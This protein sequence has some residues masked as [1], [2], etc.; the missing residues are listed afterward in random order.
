[1][2]KIATDFLNIFKK[3]SNNGRNSYNNSV[4]KSGEKLY[5]IDLRDKW[6]YDRWHIKNAVNI[7]FEKFENAEFF[8]PINLKIVL[9]CDR[10]GKRIIC[11]RKLAKRGYYCV[12]VVD[13]IENYTG[14]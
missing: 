2:S 3:I 13:G 11:S 8:I 12:N 4:V 1:M 5:I 10:G 14:D 7:S 6:Q 9:Y